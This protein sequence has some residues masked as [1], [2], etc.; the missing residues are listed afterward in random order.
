MD[1]GCFFGAGFVA[2]EVDGGVAD[3]TGNDSFVAEDVDAAATGGGGIGA[4]DAVDAEEAF[5]IDVLDDVADLVGVSFEHDDFLGF[6]FEGGPG[7]AVGVALDF[8]GGAFEVVRPNVLTGHFESG[9]GRGFEEGEEEVFVG[10]FHVG[11]VETL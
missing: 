4:T 9:G 3:D 11:V 8:G 2:A 10:L 5:V 6:S 1:G 7:G